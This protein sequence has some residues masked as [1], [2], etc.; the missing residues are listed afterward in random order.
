MQRRSSFLFAGVLTL[1]AMAL[2]FLSFTF[3]WGGGEKS[4]SPGKARVSSREV[5][6]MSHSTS[7]TELAADRGEPET[8]ADDPVARGTHGGTYEPEPVFTGDAYEVGLTAFRS[9]DYEKAAEY[10]RMAVDRG[11]KGFYPRYLLGLALRFSGDPGQAVQALEDA[12][13]LKP[14]YGRVWVNLARAY[15]ET[16]EIEP[17]S[18]AAEKAV[19]VAGEL[20]DTWN[21]LGRVRLEEGHA[22]F[23]EDAFRKAVEVDSTNAYA[24]NNLGLT[25]IHQERFAEAI[26]PLR[27]AVTLN[28]AVDFM[29]NNLGV[30]LERTGRLDEAQEAYAQASGLGSEKAEVSLVRVKDRAE[31]LARLRETIEEREEEMAASADPEQTQETG[32]PEAGTE[33]VQD[34]VPAATGAPAD[35]AQAEDASASDDSQEENR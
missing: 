5:T 32:T 16:G 1:A 34:S 31:A 26:E 10:L 35:M 29:H 19:E 22:E 7:T 9:G 13:S 20:G 25:L 17:A 33:A 24:W 4:E 3:E 21:V 14:D 30:A 2:V 27:R 6:P 12:A 15:L 11:K 18:D 28:D 23:A 8:L